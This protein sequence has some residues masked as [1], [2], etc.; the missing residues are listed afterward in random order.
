MKRL[1]NVWSWIA[2]WYMRRDQALQLWKSALHERDEMFEKL[3]GAIRIHEDTAGLSRRQES[4]IA[5][6]RER[7]RDLEGDNQVMQAQ[8]ELYALWEARERERLSAETAM[9]A[10]RKIGVEHTRQSD[11]ELL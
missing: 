11:G 1:S 6:L 10:R 7:V 5:E 4:I 3:E 9:F 2:G 8:I